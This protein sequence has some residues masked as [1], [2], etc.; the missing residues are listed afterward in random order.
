MLEGRK[1]WSHGNSIPQHA[2]V[3]DMQEDSNKVQAIGQRRATEG[4]LRLRPYGATLRT[5]GGGGDNPFTLSLRRNA[6]EAEGPVLSVAVGEVEGSVAVG[7]VE[8]SVAVGEVE[9][10]VAVGEVE[11]SVAVGKGEGLR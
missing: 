7:E 3:I 1:G 11:G 4:I 9:G 10:S 5:N 6:P 2:Q 8:G